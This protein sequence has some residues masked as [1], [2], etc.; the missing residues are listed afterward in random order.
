MPPEPLPLFVYG[1]LK[2]GHHRHDLMAGSRRLGPARTSRTFG[3]V[4]CGG[5]PGLV[6]LSSPQ[7]NGVSG[8]LYNVDDTHLRVLDAYEAVDTGEYRR[9]PIMV[10]GDGGAELPAQAYVYALPH[11]ALP[12]VSNEWTIEHEAAFTRAFP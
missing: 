9:E 2:R 7:G 5:Y 3:L 10:C 12:A 8:E 4:D 11:D 6:R 1:T